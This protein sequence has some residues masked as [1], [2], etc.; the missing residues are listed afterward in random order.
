MSA[1]SGHVNMLLVGTYT[2]V[3]TYVDAGGNSGSATRIVHVTDQTAAVV[4]L[5]GSGVMTVAHGGTFT[6]PGA[7]WTDNVDGT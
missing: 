4:T 5:Y 1:T 7:S 2:L 3:Y 6:D